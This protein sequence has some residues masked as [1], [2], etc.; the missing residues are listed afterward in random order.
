MS[1]G[2]GRV[3]VPTRASLPDRFGVVAVAVVAGI[4]DQPG[5]ELAK[6]IFTP[7]TK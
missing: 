3:A 6:V 1:T 5:V 2:F 7:A 4:S